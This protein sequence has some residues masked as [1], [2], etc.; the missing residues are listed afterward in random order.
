MR[1][2]AAALALAS[3]V[4][5]MACQE[6]LRRP[7]PR[8]LTVQEVVTA[9][10]EEGDGGACAILAE[11]YDKGKNVP[12]DRA[13]AAKTYYRACHFEHARSCRVRS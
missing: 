6:I 10:C 12:H 4:L 7:D 3:A 9:R 11:L 1:A 13:L 8:A 2:A 5:A